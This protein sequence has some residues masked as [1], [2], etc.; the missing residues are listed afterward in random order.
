MSKK[1]IIIL[2]TGLMVLSVLSVLLVTK[3]G[4]YISFDNLF[5]RAITDNSQIPTSDTDEL[6]TLTI[7]ETEEPII[8]ARI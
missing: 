5:G 3:I 4:H 6:G 1:K 7:S 2:A 8:D